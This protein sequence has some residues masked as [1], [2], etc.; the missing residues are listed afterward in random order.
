MPSVVVARVKSPLSPL[1][2]RGGRSFQ[3][4]AVLLPP[5]VKPPFGDKGGWGGFSNPDHSLKDRHAR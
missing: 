4:D 3:V 2:E 1:Y 5:F